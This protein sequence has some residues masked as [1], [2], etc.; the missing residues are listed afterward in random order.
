MVSQILRRQISRGETDGEKMFQTFDLHYDLY[1]F[2][3]KRI[4]GPAV[5]LVLK[6][7]FNIAR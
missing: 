5:H 1:K 7:R 6:R 2:L 3:E 4:T